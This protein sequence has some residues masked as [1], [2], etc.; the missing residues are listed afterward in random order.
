MKGISKVASLLL[1]SIAIMLM[2]K[3]IELI[4]HSFR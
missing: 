1:A 3:G 4:I 2:R